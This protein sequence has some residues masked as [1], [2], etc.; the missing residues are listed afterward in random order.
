VPWRQTR[1]P[2]V[3]VHFYASDKRTGRVVALIRMNP[4]CGYPTHKHRG[5]EDV[6]VL[7]GGY[8]DERGEHRAGSFVHYEDGSSHGPV[9]LA[10]MQGQ[11]CVLLAVAHEGVE[12]LGG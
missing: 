7:Q 11:A 5:A 9:A 1:Y 3:S 12:L 6:V 10:S 4:D 2:G 8:R